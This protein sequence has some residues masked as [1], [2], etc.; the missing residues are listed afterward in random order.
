MMENE[1]PI[2]ENEAPQSST[3]L[4]YIKGNATACQ[5]K[6]VEEWLEADVAH[7]TELLQIARLYHAQQTAERIASRDSLQAFTKVEQK[8]A[9]K[10]RRIWIRRVAAA[11]ACIAGVILLSAIFS[12]QPV[13]QSLSPQVITIQSNPGMRTHFNLPDH[14]IVYL[15]AGSTVS[16]TVP[17]EGDKRSISLSGEAYFKVTPDPERPF[18]VNTFNGR[19]GIKVLGTE[20]NIEAYPGDEMA[21]TTLVEGAVSILLKNEDGLITEHLLS[22]SQKATYSITN[23]SLGIKTVNTMLETGWMSGKVIFRDTPLPEVL[24]K[25]SH[26]YD[27]DFKVVDRVIE[28]YFFTGTFNNRQLEHVLEYLKISSGIEYSFTRIEKDASETINRQTIILRKKK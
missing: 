22:P 14:S 8:I 16:Y 3:I 27:V 28:T 7:E 24:R 19:L 2:N 4:A 18:I 23:D 12:R 17:F 26:F 6:V 11:A 15:N 10:R 13:T 21:Y 25:L 1:R 5:Q 20:F 9:G